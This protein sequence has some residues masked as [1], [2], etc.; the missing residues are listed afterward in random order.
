MLPVVN[1]PSGFFWG[2]KI[3]AKVAQ[4]HVALVEEGVVE[5]EGSTHRL[6]LMALWRYAQILAQQRLVVGVGTV[7]NDLLC[8]THRSFAAQVGHALL[9]DDDVDIVLR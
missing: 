2:S 3:F 7:F 9:C 4:A 6:W 8:A 5:G 1:T